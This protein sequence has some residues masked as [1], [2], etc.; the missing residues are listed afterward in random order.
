DRAGKR[1]ETELVPREPASKKEKLG[2]SSQ[3]LVAA[4]K[5]IYGNYCK[6]SER[7][8]EAEVQLPQ[9]QPVQALRTSAGIPAEVRNLPPVFPRIGAQGRDPGR[10]EVELVRKQWSVNSGQRSVCSWLN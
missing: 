4:S 3:E 7:R 2:A 9:T 8:A 5:R 6:E 1:G 10:R